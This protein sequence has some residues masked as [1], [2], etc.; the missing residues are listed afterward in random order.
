MSAKSYN[1]CV[2]K[3]V[4]IFDS[5]AEAD[6]AEALFDAQLTPD[7][8]LRIAIQLRDL[9]HADAAQQGLARVCRVVELEQS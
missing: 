5:F 2:E 1:G 4:R 6:E 9:R 3:V 7:E 8:R